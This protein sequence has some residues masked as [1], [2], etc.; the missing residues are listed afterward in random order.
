MEGSNAAVLVMEL[1]DAALPLHEDATAKIRP[2]IF[3]EGNF[4]VDLKPGTPG[5]PELDSGRHDQGHPDGHAGPARR[6]ADVAAERL[7]RGPPGACSTGLNT[8]LNSEPTAEEDADV[9]PARAAARPAAESFNDALD[10]IP[11]AERS[12]AQVLEALLGTEP[13]RDVARLIRGTAN[14]ADELARYENELK[15]LIT[16]LNAD[17]GDVRERVDEPARLDPRAGADAAQRQRA[18]STRSTRR[19]RRRARSRPR[20]ARACARRRPRSRPRSRGSSRRARS[21][22]GRARRAGQGALARDAPTSRAL[23]DR[24]TELLP[25]T[26]L[27]R[28]VPARR[29][30]ADR[31]PRHPRRVHD[32]RGEL[33]GVLLRARGHRR[34]GPELRRQRHVR[35]L[36]DRRRLADASRSARKSDERRR[37]VRQQHRGA[38]RQPPGVPGQAAAV[39]ARRALPQADARRRQRPGGGEVARRPARTARPRRS[40]AARQAAQ[41]RPTSHA[42]RKKLNPFGTPKRAG[43]EKAK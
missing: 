25:Q 15:D 32:R 35:A 38:A 2:R 10:D 31:R 26:D 5:A 18:R 37:A 14:T 13:G 11:A 22:A 21:S 39:Q 24:A 8:A 40:P 33:Q 43:A 1:D 4:F 30:A 41:A 28:Q 23:I 27:A 36:P 34:R 20:S 16:N 42:V 12:T 29:R 19:S 7:A 9:R 6:G 17:D 3:L